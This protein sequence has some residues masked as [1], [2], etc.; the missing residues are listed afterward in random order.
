V[1]DAVANVPR[2]DLP[3]AGVAPNPDHGFV[4]SLPAVTVKALQTGVHHVEVFAT[5]SAAHCGT[6][7]WKLPYNGA[8]GQKHCVI[9]G[10][11]HCLSHHSPNKSVSRH[12]TDVANARSCCP[13][14]HT[15][16]PVPNHQRRVHRVLI[17]THE[18]MPLS[19]ASVDTRCSRTPLTLHPCARNAGV[20]ADCPPPSPGAATP[21]LRVTSTDPAGKRPSITLNGSGVGVTILGFVVTPLPHI[22]A[23]ASGMDRDRWCGW[24]AIVV[25]D[26]C[27]VDGVCW[28]SFELMCRL[29]L[30]LLAFWPTLALLA[31]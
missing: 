23:R 24:V 5:G 20:V 8:V 21:P 29:D 16:Q 15:Q 7:A 11:L 1:V 6:F 19:C 17:R 25:D 3:K 28:G 18:C 14:L 31:L 13:S 2:A 30:F 4:V 22:N 27:C 10:A 26:G 12:P 9:D